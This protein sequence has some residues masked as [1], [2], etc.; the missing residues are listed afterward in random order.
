MFQWVLD[1][2]WVNR[3]WNDHFT[4]LFFWLPLIFNLVAYTIRV[5]TRIQK[6]KEVFSE[7]PAGSRQRQA[8]EWLRFGHIV[9]YV[10]LVI[11]P[12][13]NVIAFVFDTMGDLWRILWQ[14]FEHLFNFRFIGND[15]ADAKAEKNA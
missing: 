10:A 5:G 7:Y 3:T 1:T 15:K 13:V 2:F 9:G 4:V 6:D 12:F 14:R 11:L 8:H